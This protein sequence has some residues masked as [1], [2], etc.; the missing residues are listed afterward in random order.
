[1]LGR[2]QRSGRRARRTV[3]RD[4]RIGG[5]WSVAR[6]GGT[7]KEARHR[8][9]AGKRTERF[10]YNFPRLGVK[11]TVFLPTTNV[12][13]SAGDTGTGH[14][15]KKKGSS[16]P[17][18]RVPAPINVVA[19]TPTYAPPRTAVIRAGVSKLLDALDTS[20]A[21]SGIVFG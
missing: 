1:M 16:P 4:V 15:E 2:H 19:R 18:E 14:G 20:A 21:Y 8:R 13:F 17:V 11:P 9:L 5:G 7:A 3:V 10:R 12:C 6:S